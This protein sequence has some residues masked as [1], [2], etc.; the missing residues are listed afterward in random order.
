MGSRARNAAATIA[1]IV[2][3]AYFATIATIGSTDTATIAT[4]AYFE[5]ISINHD[6]PQNSRA[7]PPLSF[8][9]RRALTKSIIRNGGRTHVANRESSSRQQSFRLEEGPTPSGRRMYAPE[10][11]VTGRRTNRKR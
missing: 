2:T 5:I 9:R 1:T 11:P 6:M 3:K 7:R 4:K 8:T 10:R